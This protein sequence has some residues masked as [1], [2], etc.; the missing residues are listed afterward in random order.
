MLKKSFFFF[1]CSFVKEQKMKEKGKGKVG[2]E[3]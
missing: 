2:F 3:L 1:E